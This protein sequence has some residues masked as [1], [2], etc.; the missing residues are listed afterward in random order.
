MR[1]EPS[2]ATLSFFRG[3]GAAAVSFACR[4]A[5]SPRTASTRTALSPWMLATAF[6]V[7]WSIVFIAM[8][9]SSGRAALRELRVEH[10]D[11]LREV[12]GGDGEVLGVLALRAEA[13]G[14]GVLRGPEQRV[15]DHRR[16]D[17]S[18]PGREDLR[19]DLRDG[20]HACTRSIA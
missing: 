11:G 19:A 4:S 7:S 12:Q 13:L 15:R 1:P 17:L 16:V 18:L 9:C 6:C 2:R 8:S 3:V 14:R 10:H 5:L 20:A